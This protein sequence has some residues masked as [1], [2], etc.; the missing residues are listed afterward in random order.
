ML[1]IIDFQICTVILLISIL[2]K[3]NSFSN[4]KKLLK[5]LVL[6]HESLNEN[7]ESKQM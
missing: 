2:K 7:D 6:Y 4:K 5:N 1:K 3:G